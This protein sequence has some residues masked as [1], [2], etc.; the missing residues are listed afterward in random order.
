MPE[1]ARGIGLSPLPS[2]TPAQGEGKRKDAE[3]FRM[4]RVGNRA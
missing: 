2:I 1:L 4:A 3:P